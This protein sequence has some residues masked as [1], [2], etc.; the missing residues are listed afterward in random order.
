MEPIITTTIGI[1]QSAKRHWHLPVL[2]NSESD[3]EIET[4]MHSDDERPRF[5]T[6]YF[7]SR[8]PKLVGLWSHNMENKRLHA[9]FMPFFSI[10]NRQQVSP[11]LRP[12][13]TN[14]RMW[15]LGM[16]SMI[17]N[18]SLDSR[19]ALNVLQQNTTRNLGWRRPSRSNVRPAGNFGEE[20]VAEH[21]SSEYMGPVAVHV[22]QYS[23]QTKASY[24]KS[25]INSSCISVS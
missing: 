17:S 2:Y 13:P 3:E 21:F 8:T 19:R 12:F 4:N 5:Q 16:T 24:I 9:G 15:G 7:C 10:T 18:V 25:F 1:F 14:S 11:S 6:R 23:L 22:L 20:S